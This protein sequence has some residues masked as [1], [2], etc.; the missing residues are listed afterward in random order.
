MLNV[1]CDQVVKSKIMQSHIPTPSVP[2]DKSRPIKQIRQ[3]AIGGFTGDH[4]TVSAF[5]DNQAAHSGFDEIP[6]TRGLNLLLIR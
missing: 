4:C 1:K 2:V 5:T 3:V 6:E